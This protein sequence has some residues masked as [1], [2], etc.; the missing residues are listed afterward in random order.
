MVLSEAEKLKIEAEEQYRMQVRSSLATEALAASADVVQRSQNEVAAESVAATATPL[1]SVGLTKLIVMNIATL[2]IY[3]IYWQ[4]KHWQ[5]IKER[6]DSEILPL[7]RAIFAPIY[8]Y[9]LLGKINKAAEEC[10]SKARSPQITLTLVYVLLFLSNIFIGSISLELDLLVWFVQFAMVPFLVMLPQSVAEKVNKRSIPNYKVN[11][12]FSELNW[13]AIVLGI[14][15]QLLLLL[16][17]AG[18]EM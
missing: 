14:G 11:A 16:A 9:F 8:Y 1:F 4:Y 2:G 17:A 5:I 7:L 15:L 13:L 10:G 18:S 3:S 6:E 12:R